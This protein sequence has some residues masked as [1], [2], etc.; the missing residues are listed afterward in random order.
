MNKLFTTAYYIA[1]SERP[2]TDFPKLLHLQE[3][4]G[5]SFGDAYHNDKSARTFVKNIGGIYFDHLR[6]LLHSSDYFS[7]FCDGT[8]DKADCEKEVI[9][10]KVLEDYYPK[11]KYFKLVE[12]E[13]TK[14]A[15]ILAAI[16]QAFFE[17]DLQNYKQKTIG[18]CSDGA[19]VMV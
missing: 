8:T 9:L 1:D 3:K 6:S 7:I 10:V 18:F 19:S 16:D 5:L 17:A 12:P 14:A 11:M 2:F 13:N 15:G 4:N